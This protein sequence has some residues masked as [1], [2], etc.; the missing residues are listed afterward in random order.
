MTAEALPKIGTHQIEEIIEFDK[1]CFGGNRKKLLESIIF[2]KDNVGYYTLEGKE[3]VGYGPAKV[4]GKMAEIGPPA[5][6][7]RPS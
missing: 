1:R 3:V 6:Q 5:C 4:Y 2:E 7:R